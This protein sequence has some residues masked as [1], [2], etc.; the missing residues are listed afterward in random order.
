MDRRELNWIK[1]SYSGTNG[2]CVEAASADGAVM[3]R[4]TTNRG[5]GT[6]TF[7]AEAWQVFTASL[8]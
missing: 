2:N 5:G 8:R 6:L 3:A 4:D 7:T 1:S